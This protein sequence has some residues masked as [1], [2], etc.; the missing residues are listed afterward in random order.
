MWIIDHLLEEGDELVDEGV[1][2]GSSLD[3]DHHPPGALQL[4]H[5]LLQGVGTNHVCALGLRQ[6]TNINVLSYVAANFC[7]YGNESL[8]RVRLTSLFKKS[9]TLLVVL[10]YATTC[11]AKI[12]PALS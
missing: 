1:H 5:H 8:E 3:E 2:G 11:K 10:L 4:P 6:Q 12:K 9:S 7:E